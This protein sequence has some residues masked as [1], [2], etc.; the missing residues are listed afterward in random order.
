M[1]YINYPDKLPPSVRHEVLFS[2]LYDHELGYAVYLPA[3][4]DSSEKQYPVHYHLHGWQGCELSDIGV[5]EQVYRNSETIY[6]FPNISDELGEQKA[7]PAEQMFFEELIPEIERRYRVSRDRRTISGFSMGGGMAIYFAVKHPGMFSEV[8]SYAGTFHHYY[9]KDFVT[10]FEPV[11]RAEE[12]YCGM[13]QTVWESD[14]NLLAWF[15]ETPADSFRLT[16]RVGTDDPLYCDSE[17]LHR[18]LLS[19]DFSHEYKIFNGAGHS[20]EDI[21]QEVDLW[22]C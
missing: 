10:A 4:Y 19:L 20:L 7:L 6:V 21:I 9:H 17:V 22:N 12:L 14:R 8:I 1:N 18:H 13:K 5:M 16:L 2:P 15:D 3:D 11:E